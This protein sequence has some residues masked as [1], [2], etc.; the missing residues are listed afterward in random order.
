MAS[1][2]LENKLYTVRPGDTLLAI[3]RTA[4]MPYEDLLALNPQIT[5]PNL[6]RAGDMLILP[7]SVSRQSLLVNMANSIYPGKDMPLWYKIAQHEV[8]VKE[9]PGNN[10]R[11]LEYL[12]TTK[13]SKADRSTDQT[14]WCSAFA[15]LCLKTAGIAGTDSA[16][17]LNWQSWGKSLATPKLGAVVVFTRKGTGVNGGHVGFFVEET[18]SRITVLGGN[19]GDAVSVSTYPR[20]G[21]KGKLHYKLVGYRWP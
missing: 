3:A 2:V 20:D 10:P 21:M 7:V 12:A 8:G 18:A 9:Q 16:W 14:A 1:K 17:A 11:I 5:N 13:L 19:Q 15:N 4:D 6:I